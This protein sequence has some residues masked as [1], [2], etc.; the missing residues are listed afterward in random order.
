MI[1]TQDE[2]ID[3]QAERIAAL[4]SAIRKYGKHTTHV[5]TAN[6]C[7]CGLDAL[8]GWTPVSPSPQSDESFMPT[9][10]MV[11]RAA[12]VLAL[13]AAPKAP[14]SDSAYVSVPKVPTT[15]IKQAIFNTLMGEEDADHKKG[16]WWGT[17][18]QVELVENVYK[19]ML[20]AARGESGMSPA[21]LERYRP[22]VVRGDEMSHVTCPDCKGNE[23]YT[24]YGFA[25]GPLGG[26]TICECGTLLEFYP[27]T[28]GMPDD[29]IEKMRK[30]VDE[31]YAEV[32]GNVAGPKPEKPEIHA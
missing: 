12:Q 30:F 7:H 21:A 3:E 4:E 22:R 26:Y 5:C 10:D 15:L 14:Q 17:S 6:A 19:A 24:G 2:I 9:E 18:D 8:L 31:W 27:D 29:F 1:Q 13:E 23:H 28:D 16:G 32:W 25:A 11:E 20:A